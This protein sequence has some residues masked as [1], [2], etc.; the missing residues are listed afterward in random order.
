MLSSVIS[1]NNQLQEFKLGSSSASRKDSKEAV[2]GDEFDMSEP[3]CR[4][5]RT[6]ALKLC[7][8]GTPVSFL[9]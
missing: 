5:A 6:V 4:Q 3:L 9:V 7:E 1:K 2:V 8:F